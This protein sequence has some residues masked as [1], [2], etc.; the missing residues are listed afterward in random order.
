MEASQP[1]QRNENDVLIWSRSE[2]YPHL[3]KDLVNYFSVF[4]RSPMFT[5]M[6]RI[7]ERTEEQPLA[8]MFP[9]E[10]ACSIANF[11]SRKWNTTYMLTFP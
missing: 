11:H 9:L 3:R 7:L 2:S 10:T 5:D 6:K 8:A 4:M 1:A